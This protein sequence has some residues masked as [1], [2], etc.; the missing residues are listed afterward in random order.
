MVADHDCDTNRGG[1][2]APS[3]AEIRGSRSAL[4][5]WSQNSANLRVGEH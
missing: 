3:M 1:Q 2:R 5:K 4:T